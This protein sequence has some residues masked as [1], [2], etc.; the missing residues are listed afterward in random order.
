M[1]NDIFAERLIYQR[2]LKG[3]SQEKL[4]DLTNVT[5]RTIQRVEKGEVQPQLRTV[6]LL[7]A[8]LEI[9]VDDLLQLNDPRQESLQKKW[10]L[11]M[12][13]S[14][15]IGFV[16]PLLNIFLPL[17]L[18]I[19]K[20]D[21]NVIYDNHGRAV[22]NFQISMSLLSVLAFIGLVTIEG[23]GFFFFI[24]VIPFVILVMLANVIS[25]LH[26]Q[27]YFYPLSVPFIRQKR[28]ATSSTLFPLLL[29]STLSML[30]PPTSE[31]T[32][33]RKTTFSTQLQ[34]FESFLLNY[35][36]KHHIPG[37]SVAI[38]KDGNMVYQK[39]HGVSH[40]SGQVPV[41]PETPF[42]IAS[43][44]KL[45]VGTTFLSLVDN[46]E[47]SLDDPISAMPEFKQY[48]EWLAG[49]GI[50]FGKNLQCDQTFKLKHA[51]NHV[52]NGKVDS[53]F[54][55]NSIFYSR[56]SRFLEAKRGNS[57]DAAK[58]RHNELAQAIT[59][60]ILIPAKMNNSM[61]GLWDPNRQDVYFRKAR[62]YGIEDNQYVMRREPQRH[63][64]GGA[65]VSATASDIIK[66]DMALEAGTILSANIKA[67][68]EQPYRTENGT[69]IPY[70]YGRYIQYVN[71]EKIIWHGG[72]DEEAGFTA[73]YLKFPQRNLTIVV[74]AN[75]EGLWWGNPLDKAEIEKSPVF[76]AAAKIFNASD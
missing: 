39:A 75:N 1:K 6:K 69:T 58:G 66:F 2:K 56:L 17:F 37:L 19:H 72:W 57:I 4:A 20:K 50:V 28:S 7:A 25:V 15:F 41:T 63:M 49:S 53:A 61:A 42:W 73:V 26:S 27:K 8:A 60:A 14:P 29:M 34:Q 55:Y 9:E 11:L 30:L 46:G 3:Y 36:N 35:K 67:L 74:L 64:A 10:L 54:S 47:L 40:I 65:G 70:A 22:I 43:V 51:L 24:A 18:W 76:Q 68:T 62:G 23:Y 44:S 16:L 12:H 48:C 21:D 13:A 33:H 31:A 71:D 45:F 52:V 32:E 59:E 5:V 38:S